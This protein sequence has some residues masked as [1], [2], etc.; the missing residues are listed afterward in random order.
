MDDSNIDVELILKNI[1]DSA[2]QV[3]TQAKKAYDVLL[4][5]LDTEISTTPYETVYQEDRVK[6]KHYKPEKKRNKAQYE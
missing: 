4:D 5:E 1:A 2:S 3:G 6:L